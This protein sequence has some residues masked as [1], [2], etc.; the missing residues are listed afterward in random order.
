MKLDLSK[1]K[2]SQEKYSAYISSSTNISGSFIDISPDSYKQIQLKFQHEKFI[3]GSASYHTGSINHD[4]IKG[5]GDVI[6]KIAN[7]I[8]KT[9]DAVFK[10]NIQGCSACAQR[11]AAL[12]LFIPLN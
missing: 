12:N 7:P 4:S 11:R 9:L 6:H 8:A 3:S 1:L 10:T 2:L 5:L